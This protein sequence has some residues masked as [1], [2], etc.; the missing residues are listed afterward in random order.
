MLCQGKE[1][2][3]AV[4]FCSLEYSVGEQ[5]IKL[6]FSEYIINWFKPVCINRNCT[7]APA[8]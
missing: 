4:I 1:V 7:C 2:L 8:Q 3:P 6:E 5:C